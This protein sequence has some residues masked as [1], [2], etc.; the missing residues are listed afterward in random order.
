MTVTYPSGL[1][2]PGADVFPAD[3]RSLAIPDPET[4]DALLSGSRIELFEAVVEQGGDRLVLDVQDGSTAEDQAATPQIELRSTLISEAL[5][6]LEA[7]DI[8]H[9]DA[10]ATITIRRGVTSRDTGA[11]WFAQG[12]FSPVDVG[13]DYGP[14]GV[15]IDVIA[16]DELSART[17]GRRLPRKVQLY[18][19]QD[20]EAAAFQ[21]LADRDPALRFET[22]HTTGK[23]TARI[24]LGPE[25]E[26]P[27]KAVDDMLAKPAGARIVQGAD[28]IVRML[29]ITDPLTATPKASWTAGSASV[30]QRLKL[31]ATKS[32]DAIC[33]AW[34]G[35]FL[36]IPEDRGLVIPFDGD[37][38]TF[39]T[40][41][42]ARTAMEAQ[43][44][45][46]RGAGRELDVSS[47]ANYAL[48]A[49]DVVDFAAVGLAF[50]AR[51]ARR[52]LAF[53]SPISQ[54]K[55]VDRREVL[56]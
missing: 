11:A 43:L 27:V 35:G 36:V 53:R 52:K 3:G 28:G 14:D 13:A 25:G 48:H 2:Y 21:V 10:G 19:G 8:L 44:A 24:T 56:G 4:V 41:D 9:P 47:W 45:L 26:D 1:L 16:H 40:E 23:V 22:G 38:S 32:P 42:K 15:Q 50:R 55:L 49:G 31:R 39:D 54:V 33:G 18:K 34:Q 6:P 7:S 30:I 20:V 17:R 37:T 5:S 29:P 12:T 51:I 46:K